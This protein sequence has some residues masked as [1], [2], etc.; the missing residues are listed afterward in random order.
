M[1]K[2]ILHCDLN[3]FFASVECLDNPELKNYP[4]AVCGNTSERHGIVLAKNELAKAYDI[5]TGEVIWQA[6][7]K[8][9]GLIIVPP[10]MDRYIFFSKKAIEI[11]TQYT[12]L[13][14]PFG[15]DECWLDVSGSTL[16]FGNGGEIAE[17]IRQQVKKELG[18][19]IS[20][21]VSFNKIFAKLG[22]DLKK[23]DAITKIPKNDYQNIVWKLQANT[24]LG[25]GGA[26]NQK[27]IKYGIHTIGDIAKSQPLFLSSVLGKNGEM[28]W[29][30]ANGECDTPVA[31]F[32]D[33]TIPKSIGNSTTTVS[34]LQTEEEVWVVL[35]KLC[36]SVAHRLRKSH[37]VASAIQITVKDSS[38]FSKE[39]QKGLGAFTRHPLTLA[40]E[41]LELFKRNYHWEKSVR[42]IGLRAIS[43][44]FEKQDEQFTLMTDIKKLDELE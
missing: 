31:R 23:P 1:E 4:V 24:L 19:T 27:L 26:T 40:K 34:D 7:R 5:K 44:D 39:F 13:V 11:Y 38:L 43:L 2:I 16:L 36:E 20:V 30:F 15:I 17:K 41:G 42:A 18:L 10:N 8:C 33:V 22:S 9:P 14:E 35:Y 21:G 12:D 25:V 28:L 3:N 37:L 32:D 6:K 29:H